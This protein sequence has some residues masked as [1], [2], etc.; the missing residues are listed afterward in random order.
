M[1]KYPCCIPGR[2][3]T[4]IYMLLV[5]GW[6]NKEIATQ[7]ALSLKTVKRHIS[8]VFQKLKVRNRAEAVC[9]WHKQL[10]NSNGY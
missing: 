6:L 3:E 8:N 9:L 4:E 10:S 2:W 5:K 1:G 7:T